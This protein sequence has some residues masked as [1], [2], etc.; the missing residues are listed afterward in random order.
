MEAESMARIAKSAP[1]QA[2]NIALTRIR[3]V[4][5][6]SLGAVVLG[7]GAVDTLLVNTLL[8]SALREGHG[9]LTPQEREQLLKHAKAVRKPFEAE[10]QIAYNTAMLVLADV[11]SLDAI[12][13]HQA[14]KYPNAGPVLA[15]AAAAAA[16]QYGHYVGFFREKS[17]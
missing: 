7:A 1:Q 12:V 6:P 9:L 5:I 2:M 8:A 16:P 11:D 17:G 14:I 15:A 13:D 3:A 4:D 10:V